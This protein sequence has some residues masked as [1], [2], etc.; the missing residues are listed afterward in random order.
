MKNRISNIFYKQA[1]L[2]VDRYNAE[3]ND[4]FNKNGESLFLKYILKG[5]TTIFDV[6]ANIGEYSNIIRDICPT[7]CLH[8]FE[9]SPRTF[10]ILKSNLNNE[11]VKL[12]NAGVGS[13]EGSMDLFTFGDGSKINS[14]YKREGLESGWGIQSQRNSEKVKII[15]LDNY[16]KVNSIVNISFI[17]VDVEG[18][19]LE[20]LKGANLL[21]KNDQ[22]EALQF[23][24]GGT[25]IDSRVLLKDIFDFV[26]NIN[27]KLYKI[28]P[29]GLAYQSR[30]DQRLENFQY[31][32]FAL[33]N[34]NIQDKVSNIILK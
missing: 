30:Y 26:S 13:S 19:E 9:P 11:N 18:H 8:C 32:N 15:T 20:V 14:L 34:N 3:N 2:V 7:G 25:N 1:K 16:A 23:E 28:T 31:K 27:Y 24:Y 6:G 17:K 4:D 29:V 12:N 10:L 21:L 22:I 5:A 33:I